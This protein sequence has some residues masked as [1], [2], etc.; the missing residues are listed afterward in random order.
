VTTA[1]ETD[2][3]LLAPDQVLMQDVARF[4]PLRKCNPCK[5]ICW[6]TQGTYARRMSNWWI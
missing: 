2:D 5:F 4:L 1:L 3:N 6:P